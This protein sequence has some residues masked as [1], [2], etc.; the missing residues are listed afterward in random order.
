MPRKASIAL[1]MHP[2]LS[3]PLHQYLKTK[4]SHLI[5]EKLKLLERRA[6]K[7]VASPALI[8]YI[9]ITSTT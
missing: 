8:I 1:K 5:R 3:F 7:T 9:G 6:T 4:L 2:P